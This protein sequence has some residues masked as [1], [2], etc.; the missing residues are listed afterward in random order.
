MNS[1][2]YVGKSDTIISDANSNLGE[3]ILYLVPIFAPVIYKIIDKIMEFAHDA[4][5]HKYDIRIKA[6]PVDFELTKGK[7]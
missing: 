4:M 2:I 6:G 3:T 5:E 1:D 7:S